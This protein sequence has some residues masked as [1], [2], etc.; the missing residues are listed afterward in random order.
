LDKKENLDVD[1]AYSLQTPADSVRLYEKWADTYDADFVAKE[2]YVA[3]LRVAEVFVQQPVDGSVL[4]VG[5]GTGGVGVSLR[6]HGVE[7]I[8]GVDISPQMLAVAANKKAGDGNAVYRGLIAADLTQKLDFPDDQFAGIISAGT[9]THGHLGPEPLDELWRVAA[10]G[11][12]CVIGVRTTHFE[13]LGFG[14]KL[15][16]DVAARK[17]TAPEF[18]EINI[19]DA[20]EQNS[21]HA[22]DRLF[23]VVCQV[24]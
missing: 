19:Y 23:V 20:R 1:D 16:A 4:D 10:P 12:R 6:E 24:V 3:H 14:D 9:F 17:I 15:D 8:V 5:C 21:T 13:A 7:D 11:A 18:V 2:A 22:G